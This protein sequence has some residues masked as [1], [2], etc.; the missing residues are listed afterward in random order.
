MADAMLPKI[1]FAPAISVIGA[2][3][4]RRAQKW[5]DN[6]LYN[7]I[8]IFAAD[9]LPFSTIIDSIIRAV[10]H[11]WIV[12][13]RPGGA[14][15]PIRDVSFAD[16][17]KTKHWIFAR[18]SDGGLHPIDLLCDGNPGIEELIEVG[19][20]QLASFCILIKPP[21]RSRTDRLI[22]SAAKTNDDVPAIQFECGLADCKSA[23]FDLEE[24]R[25]FIVENGL[26]AARNAGREA[27]EHRRVRGIGEMARGLGA[28]KRRH[29][30]HIGRGSCKKRVKSTRIQ[31]DE[32]NAVRMNF[33]DGFRYLASARTI[34]SLVSGL[35]QVAVHWAAPV[36][37]ASGLVEEVFR[38]KVW[39]IHG[40]RET[41]K[42][43]NAGELL[44]P[45]RRRDV[46]ALLGAAVG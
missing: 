7:A 8:D 18:C 21:E 33:H 24:F 14:F 25:E 10:G 23:T 17:H 1:I 32:K 31:S 39:Q 34:T 2:N 19:G 9:L 5:V 27:E 12:A 26:F 40:K 30:L 4:N 38:T 37:C 16:I 45:L 35:W 6:L 41:V 43:N 20:Q 36:L 29:R 42:R 46:F 13:T 15:M 44:Q 11:A 3:E 28:M 22:S